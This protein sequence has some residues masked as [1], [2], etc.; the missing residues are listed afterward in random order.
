M[1]AAVGGEPHPDHPGE[2]AVRMAPRTRQALSAG[3]FSA[4]A[5]AEQGKRPRYTPEHWERVAETYRRA[6]RAGLS[7]TAAVAEAE[8]VEYPTAA[9][10]VDRCRKKG[11]LGKAPGRGRAGEGEQP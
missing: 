3:G 1:E 5:W 7:P 4:A 6:Y 2:H 9:H 10:W 11:L 8:Q